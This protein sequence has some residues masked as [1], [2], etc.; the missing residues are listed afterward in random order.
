MTQLKIKNRDWGR[1][2]MTVSHRPF[3]FSAPKVQAGFEA[4][5]PE[6]AVPTSGWLVG[7]SVAAVQDLSIKAGTSPHCVLLNQFSDGAILR[8]AMSADKIEAIALDLRQSRFKVG[9]DYAVDVSLYNNPQSI[10]FQQNVIARPLQENVLLF[11]VREIDTLKAALK[12][13]RILRFDYGGTAHSYDLYGLDDGFNR[14]AA[15][16]YAAPQAPNDQIINAQKSAP[17]DRSASSL[18]EV[19]PAGGAYSALPDEVPSQKA[20]ITSSALAGHWMLT[21]SLQEV[22]LPPAA[23]S[24]V[25]PDRQWRVVMGAGLRETIDNWAMQENVRLVWRGDE[26]VKIPANATFSGRFEEAVGTLL[27][28]ARDEGRNVNGNLYFDD[29]A[30]EKVLVIEVQ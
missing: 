15:Q 2:K 22:A 6:N 11:G 17:V 24:S 7:P 28:L 3:C 26:Q 1:T 19:E 4:S 27:V 10:S 12:Q 5:L 8:I 23:I 18:S 14:A 16:C 21:P 29:R 25:V 30:D 9:A 13:N 20:T